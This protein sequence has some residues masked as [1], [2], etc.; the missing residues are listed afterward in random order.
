MGSFIFKNSGDDTKGQSAVL[1]GLISVLSGINVG[2]AITNLKKKM[3]GELSVTDK[4]KQIRFTNMVTN[5]SL[6]SY[7]LG[8]YY[9]GNTE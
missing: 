2:L 4:L 6:I 5:L 3:A 8:R 7:M 9:L 1:I